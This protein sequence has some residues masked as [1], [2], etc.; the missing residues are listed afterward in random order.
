MTR[1]DRPA[2]FHSTTIELELGD[3]L[4]DSVREISEAQHKS[5]YKQL[6]DFIREGVDRYRKSAHRNQVVEFWRPVL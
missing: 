4:L 2:S 3:R 5:L 1:I 6:R